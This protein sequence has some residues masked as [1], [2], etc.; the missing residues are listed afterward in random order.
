[1]G[2]SRAE[3]TSKSSGERL[4]SPLGAAC[5]QLNSLALSYALK[6]KAR[7]SI[8]PRT[9]S[10]APRADSRSSARTRSSSD[11]PI[12]FSW[13]N[14]KSSTP[15]A[16]RAEAEQNQAQS[17]QQIIRSGWGMMRF[18]VLEAMEAAATTFTAGSTYPAIEPSYQTMR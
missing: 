3:R 18:Q 9:R 15:N 6:N 2:K 13:K 12:T 16:G 5:H 7:R 14:A 17:V 1:M 10:S 8:S 11:V 4:I